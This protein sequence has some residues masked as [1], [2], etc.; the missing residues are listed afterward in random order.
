MTTHITLERIGAHALLTLHRPER[1]N[2]LSYAL[3]AELQACLDQL[4][5]D[6]TV[7]TVLLTGSGDK[8]FSAGADI[9]GFAPDVCHSPAQALRAFLTPGQALTRRLE[10]FPKP[11]IAAVNGLAFGGGCE[12]VEACALAVAAS[13][14]TFAKPEIKLGFPPPFGGTQR[15]PRHVGRKRALAM[16]LTGEPVNAQQ[17]LHMGLVNDVV[18][19]NELT[20]HCLALAD[21]IARHTPSSVRATLAAVTR[22]LNLPIDEAL[23]TEAM[24]FCAAL[25]SGEAVPRL[26]AFLSRP[27]VGQAG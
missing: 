3:I 6:D 4:E 18:P 17:A 24:Q 14:A 27:R 8:A 1:L 19:A 15:L 2:A 26:Q 12:V 5:A 7:R 10:N 20:S 22:G 21:R 13:H 25:A 9:H 16:L 23:H 11:V